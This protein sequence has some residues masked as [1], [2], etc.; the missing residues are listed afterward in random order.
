MDQM[1]IWMTM[2]ILNG[3]T[4]AGYVI[5]CSQILISNSAHVLEYGMIH[6]NIDDIDYNAHVCIIVRIVQFQSLL[7]II[8]TK[9]DCYIQTGSQSQ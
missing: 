6:E 5:I 8:Q 1:K 3:S 4:K 9:P 2:L 7:Q